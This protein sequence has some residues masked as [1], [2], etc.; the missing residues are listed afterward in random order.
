MRYSKGEQIGEDRKKEEN[1]K[2]SLE[3][4][5]EEIGCLGEN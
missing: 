2:V 5:E 4:R 1:S 3:G